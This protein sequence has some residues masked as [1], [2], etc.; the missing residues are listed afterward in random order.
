[1]LTASPVVMSAHLRVN[2]TLLP[3]PGMT[4]SALIVPF[5]LMAILSGSL[6]NLHNQLVTQKQQI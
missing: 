4:N 3:S 2:V 1:M 6:P 5:V